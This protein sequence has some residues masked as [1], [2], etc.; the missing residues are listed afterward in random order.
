MDARDLRWSKPE[1]SVA[2]RAYDA[3]FQRECDAVRSKVRELI[4]AASEPQ[5]VWRIHDYLT[6][7][8]DE[9]DSKYDYRYSVLPFVFARLVREGWLTMEEL[10]ELGQDKLDVIKR[11]VELNLP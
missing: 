5:D 7:K 9:V 3:A 2:R 1:K 8:R 11:V 6:D 10:A 4:D